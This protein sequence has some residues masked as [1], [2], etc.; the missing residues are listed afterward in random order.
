M[1]ESEE[2]IENTLGFLYNIKIT[3]QRWWWALRRFCKEGVFD[4]VKISSDGG[5]KRDDEQSEPSKDSFQQGRE[6][7]VKETAD[8]DMCGTWWKD[9]ESKY[10]NCR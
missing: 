8:E 1:V 3:R 2:E 6:M 5:S 7:G 10:A 4:Y 9:E